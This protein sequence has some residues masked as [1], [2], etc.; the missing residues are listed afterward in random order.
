MNKHN[1]KP[2]TYL[3]GWR[4]LDV[5]YYGVR[6]ANKVCPEE[7]LWFHYNTSSEHLKA[8][9]E[10]NGQPDV[11]RVARKF[12]TVTAA[13]RH[14]TRFIT[15]L[16]CVRSKRWLNKGNPNGRFIH[17]RPH[18]DETKALIGKRSRERFA[19]PEFKARHSESQKGR[20]V[21][22]GQKANLSIAS[23]NSWTPE[24]RAKHA[25]HMKKRWSNPEYKE[26]LRLSHTN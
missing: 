9:M 21:S 24:R 26:K 15:R 13:R 16:K 3:I 11:I 2:Y 23:K 20:V 18:S 17:S 19:D 10:E 7:D 8:F 6:W 5:W 22:E 14:E 1:Q 25:E 12:D 4:D